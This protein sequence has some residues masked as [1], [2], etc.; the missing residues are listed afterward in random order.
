VAGL[1]YP[2]DACEAGDPLTG[3]A[4]T[5]DIVGLV[6]HSLYVGVPDDGY[7]LQ[8]FH[9]VHSTDS[10][11]VA[12]AA[13]QLSSSARANLQTL[14]LAWR[15]ALGDDSA[16]GEVPATIPAL[17]GGPLGGVLVGP[18]AAY[19][20]VGTAGVKNLGA[21]AT[22]G[23]GTPFEYAASMALRALH[24]TDALPYL[25]QLLDSANQQ[26]RLNAIAGLSMALLD[27]PPLIG[28]PQGV[29]ERALNPAVRKKLSEADGAHVYFAGPDYASREPELIAWWKARA[30][31]MIAAAAGL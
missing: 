8:V 6:L 26:V 16:L 17:K 31:Q 10:P 5:D 13:G 4:T 14:G 25:Q 2:S 28:D 12:S 21:I 23:A 1:F 22:Q 15:I 29:F 7:V 9:S 30:P 3:A 27:V 19:A 20:H 18:I 24:T 11:A